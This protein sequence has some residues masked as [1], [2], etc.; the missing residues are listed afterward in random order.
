MA[1]GLE[2]ACLLDADLEVEWEL[3][4][5]LALIVELWQGLRVL[6]A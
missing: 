6:L 5:E 2:L 3:G 4:F 1:L